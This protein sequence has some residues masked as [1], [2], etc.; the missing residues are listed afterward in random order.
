MASLDDKCSNIRSYMYDLLAK[1]IKYEGFYIPITEY[2]VFEEL[3]NTQF[4]SDS[5]GLRALIP[6]EQIKKLI[7]NRSPDTS[8]A[9]CLAKLGFSLQKDTTTDLV[10]FKKE[11]DSHF[12][13]S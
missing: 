6:K 2:E 10:A 4:I 8:D 5:R 3:K 7:G 13:R 12:L 11:M 9:L 1:S